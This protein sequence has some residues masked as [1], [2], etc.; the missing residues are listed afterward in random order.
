LFSACHFQSGKTQTERNG[1]NK[2]QSSYAE[3]LEIPAAAKDRS[4]QILKRTA[5][6]VS[7][8][9]DLKIPNWVAWKLTAEDVKGTTERASS[10]YFR[11]DSEVPLPRATR[12]DYYKSGWSRGHMFP[13]GDGKRSKEV[14]EESFLLTNICPQNSRLNSGDW[15]EIENAC[16]QWASKY[17]EV[18]IVCGPVLY[19]KKHTSIGKNKVVVPEAFFKV[20]LAL[21]PEPKAIGFICKNSPG[22]KKKE[23]YVNTVDEIERITGLDFF[24]LLPDETEEKAESSADISLW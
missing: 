9:K 3:G 8:N 18:Y 1:G 2:T 19:Y 15:N 22:N 5:Y 6:T 11:E 16:R 21:T 17:K 10:N 12:E 7:Y 20:V 14:M 24:P 4:E 13:A 23:Q